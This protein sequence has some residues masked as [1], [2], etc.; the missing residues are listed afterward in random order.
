MKKIFSFLVM[1]LF[2]ASMF[3]GSV[4][5]KS[6]FTKATAP[7]DNKVT[8]LE[9]KVTWNIATTVGDSSAGDPTCVTGTSYKI[10]C[11]KFGDKGTRYFSKVEFSTDLLQGLQGNCCKTLCC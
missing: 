5:V 7:A 6:T 8:D 11:L 9:G 3:A 2:S 4:T 1:A 10:E